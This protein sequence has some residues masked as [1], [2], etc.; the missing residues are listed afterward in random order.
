MSEATIR[1]PKAE[2]DVLFPALCEIQR[3]FLENTTKI[4]G[5]FL[6][7]VGWLAT[8]ESARNYLRAES[9]VR[10]SAVA[11]VVAVTIIFC[12]VSWTAFAASRRILAELNGLNYISANATRHRR[13][14]LSAFLAYTVA[15]VCLAS[16]VVVALVR[17]ANAA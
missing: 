17:T 8:S 15:N 16:L 2:F 12:V 1:D 5:F 13:V 4:A 14:T 3:S 11:A 9:L 10:N 6:L 7:A